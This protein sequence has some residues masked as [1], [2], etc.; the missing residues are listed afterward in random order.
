MAKSTVIVT[1]VFCVMFFLIA[2]CLIMA[3]IQ[4]NDNLAMI[5]QLAG[6]H[7]LK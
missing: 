1:I 4:I 3:K 7:Y 2:I 5:K 6:Y